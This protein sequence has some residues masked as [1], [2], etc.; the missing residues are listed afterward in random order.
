MNILLNNDFIHILYQLV[1]QGNKIKIKYIVNY[2][3]KLNKLFK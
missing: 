3:R 2:Y 1:L